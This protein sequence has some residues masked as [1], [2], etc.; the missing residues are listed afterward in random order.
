MNQIS[1]NE[2][3]DFLTKVKYDAAF[4]KMVREMLVDYVINKLTPKNL[5]EN[6]HVSDFFVRKV[7][8]KFK[9]EDRKKEYD[10]KLLDTVLVKA[11]KQQAATLVK[12]TTVINEQVNRLLKKQMADPEY[13]VPNSQF[14]EL[15]SVFTVFS[16]EYRLDNDK[17]TESLG[18][19]VKVEFPS[20]VPVITENANKLK[21][22]TGEVK[23]VVEEIKEII[24]EE[25]TK[26]VD[27]PEPTN[28]S[29]SDFFGSILE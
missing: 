18:F 10:K 26:Q 4:S 2:E 21:D 16:K 14:K 28:I 25:V 9:F 7:L 15:I 6:Y 8:T 29:N 3:D 23:E 27:E 19:N 5:S 12:A 20:H 22:I 11:Q 13:I 1:N 17:V 24:K